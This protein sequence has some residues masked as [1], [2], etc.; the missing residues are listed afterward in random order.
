MRNSRVKKFTTIV[1]PS[2]YNGKFL[3]G[4]CRLEAI[5]SLLAAPNP[6]VKPKRFTEQKT[7]SQKLSPKG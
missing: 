6:R 1:V 5:K 4:H 2:N 7:I 3:D